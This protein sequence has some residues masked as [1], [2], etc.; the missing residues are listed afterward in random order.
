[1]LAF[2]VSMP[3]HAYDFQSGG[4]Y[5]AIERNHAAVTSGTYIVNGKKMIK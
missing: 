5:Y 1:M 3:M 2:L 4:I